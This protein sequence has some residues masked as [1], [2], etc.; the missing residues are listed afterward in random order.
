MTTLSKFFMTV[1]FLETKEL[2]MESKTKDIFLQ[3]ILQTIG[4]SPIKKELKIHF[5]NVYDFHTKS[6][7]PDFVWVNT[8]EKSLLAII[9]GCT[10]ELKKRSLVFNGWKN[11]IFPNIKIETT[12]SAKIKPLNG[13]LNLIRK[14]ID[15]LDKEFPNK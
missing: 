15:I 4:E 9:D 10:K 7:N 1:S 13:W 14:I 6:N 12:P 8:K 11:L 3:T 5:E 2:F